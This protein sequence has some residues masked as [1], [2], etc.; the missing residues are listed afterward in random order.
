MTR[1]RSALVLTIALVAIELATVGHPSTT[2]LFAIGLQG[3][4]SDAGGW[5]S[6]SAAAYLDQRLSWWV[7][8]KTAERDHGTFCIS[9]HTALPYALGR[10]SLRAALRAQ[11][12]AR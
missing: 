12:H 3:A 10:P 7:T 6:K 11:P 8:W 1:I 5:N 9:C 2:C 4:S